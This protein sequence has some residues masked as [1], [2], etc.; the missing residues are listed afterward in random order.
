[1]KALTARCPDCNAMVFACAPRAIVD[2]SDD[3]VEMRDLGYSFEWVSNDTVRA[4]FNMCQC[5]L[6]EAD[7]AWA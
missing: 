6:P 1:M 7:H 4:E 3:I 5:K 2:S